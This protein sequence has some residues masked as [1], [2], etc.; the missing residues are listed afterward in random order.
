MRLCAFA[1]L[2]ARVTRGGRCCHLPRSHGEQTERPYKVTRLAVMPRASAAA[3]DGL[4]RS[5]FGK[6]RGA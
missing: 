5:I 2:C 1:S 6:S 4:P 3:E